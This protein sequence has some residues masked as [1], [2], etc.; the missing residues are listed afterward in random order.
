LSFHGVVCGLHRSGTTYVGEVLKRCD[1]ILVIHE[2]FNLLTGHEKVSRWYPSDLNDGNKENI[3]SLVNDV[4]NYKG[5]LKKREG[6]YK[7]VAGCFYR[8]I[9]GRN[10]LHWFYLA[11]LKKLRASPKN[12]IWKDP[13]CTF[14]T[15]YLSNEL[16]MPIVIVMKHPCSFVYSVQKQDWSFKVSWLR[17]NHM[18]IHKYG[19]G[20]SD[21]LWRQAESCNITSLS[22]LWKVMARYSSDIATNNALVHFVRHEDLC[23][24]PLQAFNLILGHFGLTMSSEVKAYINETTSGSVLE[25]KKGDTRLFSRD[26]KKLAVLWKEKLTADEQEKIISIVGEDLNLIYPH[27]EK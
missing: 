3:T 16:Q 2:P 21:E 18:L 24:D 11:L 4:L 19:Q 22:L 13:F 26:S 9:G 1:D 14:M 10:H 7:G 12:V 5:S 8:L 6:A 25:G 27:W 23:D 20:I 15:S 17:N